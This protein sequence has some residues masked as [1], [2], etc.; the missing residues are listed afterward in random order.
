MC[1]AGRANL[2]HTWWTLLLK[3][4]GLRRSQNVTK[5]LKGWFDDDDA[6][7]WS[8]TTFISAAKSRSHSAI[9][10]SS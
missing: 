3:H 7:A 6:K 1:R 2:W 9:G 4:S 5:A 8:C 10:E